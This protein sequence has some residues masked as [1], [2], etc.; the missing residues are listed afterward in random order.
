MTILVISLLP[1]SEYF[2]LKKIVFQALMNST[3][4]LRLSQKLIP[5]PL[6]PIGNIF[7]TV[8]KGYFIDIYGKS[9]PTFSIYSDK[10][11]LQ[12]AEENNYENLTLGQNRS[13]H[14]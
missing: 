1:K 13:D 5:P 7:I 9:L 3:I 4:L 14:A 8:M 11:M 10:C 6:D 2:D 12:L